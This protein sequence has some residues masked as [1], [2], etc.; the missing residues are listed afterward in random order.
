MHL[1]ARTDCTQAN[2][3]SAPQA[4][5]SPIGDLYSNVTLIFTDMVGFT[6]MSSAMAPAELVTLLDSVFSAYDKLAE[7]RH[8]EKIKTIG[9]A[10]MLVGNL[11][12]HPSNVHFLCVEMGLKTYEV[13]E[14]INRGNKGSGRLLQQRCGVHTGTVVGGVLGH[15]TLAFDLWGLDVNYA[16]QMESQGV[17]GRVQI[18]QATYDRVKQFFVCTPRE[19]TIAQGRAV[20]AY[21]VDG[22]RTESRE[23]GTAGALR[24]MSKDRCPAEYNSMQA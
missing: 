4:G 12:R 13:L 9:D 24:H 1:Q 10:Y 21:L 23:T 7:R 8:L 14:G 18:S 20:T 11:L 19:A 22:L 15:T 17:P 16:S 3:Q 2:T 6:S 5:E